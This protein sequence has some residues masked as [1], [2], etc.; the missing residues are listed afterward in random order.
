MI[1][2]ISACAAELLCGTTTFTPAETSRQDSFSKIAAPKGPP[3]PRLRFS[4]A[5]PITS[6][7]RSSAVGYSV[8]SSGTYSSTHSGRRKLTRANRM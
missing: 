5:S 3:V 6:R 7:I 8:S 1:A 2:T 4:R